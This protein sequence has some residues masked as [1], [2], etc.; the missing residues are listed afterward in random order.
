MAKNRTII[1]FVTGRLA[2]MVLCVSLLT[3]SAVYAGTLNVTVRQGTA[4]APVV[5]G[6]AVCIF[7]NNTATQNG[8]TQTAN[9]GGVA[10]FNMG[11]SGQTVTVRAFAGGN[12]RSESNVVVGATQTVNLTLALQGNGSLPNPCQTT[13]QPPQTQPPT[14]GS[15]QLNQQRDHMR[16]ALQNANF[17]GMQL[18]S[19]FS[20]ARCIHCHGGVI[21]GNTSTRVNHRDTGG[22]ACT[23]CHTGLTQ[24]QRAEWRVVSSARFATLGAPDAARNATITVKPWIEVCNM[25]RTFFPNDT[26]LVNHVQLDSLIGWAFA[27]TAQQRTPTGAAPSTQANLTTKIQQWIALGK[28]CGLQP[29]AIRPGM[30]P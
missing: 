20:H 13:T 17:F 12:M 24:A 25:V 2:A 10:T 8:P 5:P 28:P 14:G 16:T 29:A 3:I 18:A 26:A 21:P 6:A 27:P 23:N 15:S 4:S 7:P 19:I 11:P 30:I 22:Q 1:L 9:G